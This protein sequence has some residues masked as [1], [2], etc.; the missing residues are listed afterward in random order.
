M[1]YNKLLR[2]LNLFKFIP[3]NKRE[4]KLNKVK[5]RVTLYDDFLIR[6]V[7]DLINIIVKSINQKPIRL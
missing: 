1:F 7:T 6:I 3:H 5:F 4:L 2:I